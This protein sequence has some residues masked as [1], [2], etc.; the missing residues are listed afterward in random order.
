MLR[1]SGLGFR[2]EGLG[3]RVGG[4][5]TGFIRVVYGRFCGMYKALGLSSTILHFAIRHYIE[6]SYIGSDY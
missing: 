5:C 4:V 1:V 6:F 2:A 3:L